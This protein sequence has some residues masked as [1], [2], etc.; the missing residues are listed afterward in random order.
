MGKKVTIKNIAN[1]R[2][3]LTVPDIRLNLDLLPVLVVLIQLLAS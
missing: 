2:I 3:G 1:M